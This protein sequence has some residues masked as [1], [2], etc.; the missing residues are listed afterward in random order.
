MSVFNWRSIEV[1]GMG[2]SFM[3]M[4]LIFLPTLPFAPGLWLKE[5]YI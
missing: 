1:L 4:I 2:R 3:L 5:V